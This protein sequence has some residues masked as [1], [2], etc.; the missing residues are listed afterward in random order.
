[1]KTVLEKDR[2]RLETLAAEEFSR[3]LGECSGIPALILLAGGSSLSLLEK[4]DISRLPA[5]ATI[6]MS[7]ERFSDDPKINN[8]SQL[9]ET[10]FCRKARERGAKFI[11]SRVKKGETLAGFGRRV[12]RLLRDWEDRNPNGK[13]IATFGIGEDGHT[14]GM[15]PFP[16][17]PQAFKELFEGNDWYAAY[18]AS[19]KNPHAL[20]ATITATFIRKRIR[21]GVAFVSGENKRAA[22][23]KVLSGEGTL[24]ETPARLLRENQNITLFTDVVLA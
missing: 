23:S 16:E 12:E 4:I 3:L 24:A 5:D 10:A 17:N 2:A 21:S 22:L 14:E 7:D 20:R 11:D 15:M 8:F 13:C 18:D 6:G 19:G 9:S 1:M